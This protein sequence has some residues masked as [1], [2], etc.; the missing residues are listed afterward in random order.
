MLILVNQEDI[1]DEINSQPKTDAFNEFENNHSASPKT[2]SN[3]KDDL[4]TDITIYF[5]RKHSFKFAQLQ[6]IV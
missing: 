1:F 6:F 3:R 5:P 4:C 2:T